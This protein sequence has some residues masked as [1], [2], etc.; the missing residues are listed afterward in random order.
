MPSRKSLHRCW[1][2]RKAVK[3]A[4]LIHR[5]SEELLLDLLPEAEVAGFLTERFSDWRLSTEAIRLLAHAIYRRTDGLP[6]FMV[7]A[8]D[9]AVRQ[10]WLATPN[11]RWEAQ[12]G[13]AAIEQQVPPQP[14]ADD[15]TA[16]GPAE[17]SGTGGPPPA[18]LPCPREHSLRSRRTAPSP[19]LPSPWR[20]QRSRGYECGR[21]SCIASGESCCGNKPPAPVESDTWR[22]AHR[23]SMRVR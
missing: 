22:K 19:Y 17:Y 13:A 4:L 18:S 23:T 6:F 15:R 10:G 7:T 11:G 1:S 8:V 2:S 12:V 16:A 5:Q 21:R 20:W 3:Q 9:Y 14:P